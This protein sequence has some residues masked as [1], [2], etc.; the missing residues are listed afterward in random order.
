[1]N[2][3]LRALYQEVI[4]D[5]GRHPR[6]FGPLSNTSHALKGVNPLCGD[7][8][9]LYA[10]IA[11]NRIQIIGFEGSGCAI[12]MASASLM[13]EAM[14]G[15]TLEEAK[16]LFEHFHAMLT[17]SAHPDSLLGKLS[18]FE[19]VKEYPARIKC[20]TL[21]WHTLN[22]VIIGDNQPATTE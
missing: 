13:T 16:I 6:N 7:K 15:K 9:I 11:D 8:L 12:S 17:Q 3:E 21:A 14:K 4:V 20:A 19:G 2:P 1:M 22:H 18:V 10:N 5:H